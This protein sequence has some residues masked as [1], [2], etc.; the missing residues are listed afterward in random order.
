MDVEEI[1]DWLGITNQQF[2]ILMSIYNLNKDSEKSNPKSIEKAYAVLTGKMIQTPNLFSQLKFLIKLGLVGRRES[3]NYVVDVDGITN[4]IESKKDSHLRKVEEAEAVTRKVSGF[5]SGMHAIE[6]KP[7]IE[8]MD[9]DGL[10]HSLG[11]EL[12]RASVYYSTG[13]FPTI[14][15][16]P[17]IVKARQKVEKFDSLARYVDGLWERT[18]RRKE[19]K[20][21]S[22][23]NMQ[24]EYAFGWVLDAYND[25]DLAL[26]ECKAALQNVKRVISLPNVDARFVDYPHG[27]NMLMTEVDEPRTCYLYMRGNRFRTR[28]WLKVDS[29]DIA[30]NNKATFLDI[31]KDGVKLASK[32]GSKHLAEQEKRLKEVYA[33]HKKKK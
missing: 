20:I 11:S 3:A 28:C 12:Q 25:A 27:V 30:A 26:E 22:L 21:L 2:E 33:Q 9:V 7:L 32:R 10:F 19:L 16:T 31:F 13:R 6:A 4:A 24:I 17:G 18:L 14:F 8:T 15:Y 29:Y 23:T 1:V 5:L